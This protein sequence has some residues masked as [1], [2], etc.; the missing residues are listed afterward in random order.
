MMSRRTGFLLMATGIGHFLVGLVLFHQPLA[1]IVREGIVNSIP[2][3][4]ADRLGGADFGREAAFWFVLYGPL[5][6]LLGQI[7]NRALERRDTVILRLLGWN[8]LATGAAGAL[9]MPLSGFWF[10]IGLAV[11]A[12]RDAHRLEASPD[13]VPVAAG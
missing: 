5:L 11:L 7:A 2:P 1:A 13:V 12:F 4:L 8:L 10:V 6:C 9:I 3:Q